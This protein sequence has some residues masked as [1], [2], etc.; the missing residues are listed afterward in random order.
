MCMPIL[1]WELKYCIREIAFTNIDKPFL[2]MED[3]VPD[4]IESHK[5]K[6]V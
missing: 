3:L 4:I 5:F 6:Y 2:N 1:K